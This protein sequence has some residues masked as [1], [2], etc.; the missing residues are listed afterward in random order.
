MCRARC[1]YFSTNTP[2]SPKLALPCLR[3]HQGAR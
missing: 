2:A 1:T 3:G